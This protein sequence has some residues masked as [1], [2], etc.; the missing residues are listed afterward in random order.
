MSVMKRIFFSALIVT[1]AFYLGACA[2]PDEQQRKIKQ[3]RYGYEGQD[4]AA[5]DTQTMPPPVA[6]DANAQ[7]QTKTETT[8]PQPPPPTEVTKT[9]PNAP[10]TQKKDYPYGVPVAGK[11]G[12]VTSP[13]APY[14]GLVDVRGYAPGTEVA[15]PYSSTPAKKQIFLVP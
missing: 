11:P 5:T 9:Q 13:Y 7:P 10:A 4:Q 14:A 1:T 6:P 15:C 12:Y 3:H 8:T 2:G